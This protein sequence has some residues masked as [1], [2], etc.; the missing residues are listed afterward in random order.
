MRPWS[1]VWASRALS[2]ARVTASIVANEE[3]KSAHVLWDSTIPQRSLPRVA[4]QRA[5]NSCISVIEKAGETLPPNERINDL[6]AELAL[7]ADATMA[8]LKMQVEIV[9]DGPAAFITDHAPLL[10]RRLWHLV[11]EGVA[12]GDAMRHFGRNPRVG[13]LF[14]ELAAHMGP[15]ESKSNLLPL[16]NRCRLAAIA[17]DVKDAGRV[18]VMSIWPLR[19]V[20]GGI[21]IDDGETRNRLPD[22][23]PPASFAAELDR[24]R[25]ASLR[26]WGSATRAI[27]SAAL[28]R[29]KAA[30]L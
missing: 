15:R 12:R 5:P 11:L 7:R 10:G 20:V 17:V 13:S 24:Q 2:S 1:Q 18:A 4:E 3:V 8:R 22:P 28:M 26:P 27:A 9:D 19:L 14:V 29:N 23:R 6:L 25:P 21:D 16:L 30:R